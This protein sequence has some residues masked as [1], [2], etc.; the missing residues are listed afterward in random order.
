MASDYSLLNVDQLCK[1]IDI[2][3]FN[4]HGFTQGSHTVR[5]MMLS[6]NFDIFILQEHWLTPFNLYKFNDSFPEYMCFG[7]SAMCSEVESGVLRGRPYGG[8][9]T[10]VSNRLF[11]STQF[12]CSDDRYVIVIVGNLMIVN[13]Y[14]PCVGTT[15]RSLIYE[16]VLENIAV[17][18]EK[19]PNINVIFGGDVNTELDDS[20]PVSTLFSRFAVS[21]RL[22]RCDHLFSGAYYSTYYSESLNCQSTIDFFLT[23]DSD[24]VTSYNVIDPA[25]NLS[26]HRPVVIGV[27]CLVGSKLC[28]TN[29]GNCDPD[30]QKVSYLRWDRANL[31]KYCELTRVRLTQILC[32]LREVEHVIN[33]DMIDCF[34]NTVINVLQSSAE[35]SVPRCYKNFFKY[36]WSQELTQ[37]KEKSIASCNLWKEAGRPRSGPVFSRYRSDKS[38]YKLGIKRQRQENV[39][40]YT[41]DLHDALLRKQGVAFWKCWKSKFES[42]NRHVSHVNGI[43]DVNTVA[44]NFAMHFAKSCASNTS[45]GADRLRNEYTRLRKKYYCSPDNDRYRFDAELVE[46]IIGNLKRGKAAGLDGVTSEHLQYSHPLLTC[47]LA[48]LFNCMMKLGHVPSSFGESYTVPILK[49]GTNS[50]GKSV[51]VDDFRGIAISPVLSKVLEHCILARYENLFT[52]SDNQFGFKK[53]S[54]C[55]HA[56]HAF[57]CVSDYYNSS[58]STVNVCALDLSKAFDKMNHH[59][60]FL[61]L[62]EK[63]IPSNLLILLERWFSLSITC[64]KW[65]NIF[66]TCFSISC[67]IR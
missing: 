51:T 9:M 54:G 38:A 32:D 11:N 66:S 58:G 1:N 37:L 3:S 36:W 17:W 48:K 31:A 45:V 42:G 63:R 60:L 43:T 57:R 47:V 27:E 33:T 21:N 22:N 14:L 15:N 20:S 8:V 18:I 35:S 65:C 67:G 44:E 13:V 50:H 61:K 55:S 23:S 12:V 25:L 64:V 26:D 10:L 24:I 39:T 5:D 6:D 29:T 62:M 30:N 19:Y 46:T 4:M 56:I 16:E 2:V 34:Y 41:N 53:R 52:T 59:G 7:S 40:H 49:S 28:V